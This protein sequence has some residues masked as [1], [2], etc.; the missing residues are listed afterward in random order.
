MTGEFILIVILGRVL[1]YAVQSVAGNV[2]LGGFVKKLVSCDFCLGCWL[3]FG[4]MWGFDQRIVGIPHIP[5]LSHF[6]LGIVVSFVVH[7]IRIGWTTK[8][9]TIVIE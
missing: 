2:E 1:L 4:L 9:E 8:F 3:F 7:L 5:I 6:L